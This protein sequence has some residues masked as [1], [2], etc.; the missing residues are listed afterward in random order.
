MRSLT[1]I[2]YLLFATHAYAESAA[3]PDTPLEALLLPLTEQLKV[4]D[5]PHDY[6]SQKFVGLFND[7]DRF[8]GDER[9]YQEANQ[10]VFQLDLHKVSGFAGDRQVVL[11]GRANVSLPNTEKRLH[12]LVE[13]NPDKNITGETPINQPTPIKDVSAPSSYA[14]AMRYEQAIR[15][16]L[17]L[18]TDAGIKFQGLNSTP[19]TRAR[20]S[21]ATPLDKWRMKI[22]ET[23]FWFNS[24]GIGASSQLDFERSLSPPMLMR[25]SSNATWLNDKQNFDLRQ[26]LSIFH[27][28]NER[29]AVLYQAS[30]TGASQPQFHAT[31]YV[32]LVLF[33]YRLHQKWMFFEVSPQLHFPQIK[34]YQTSPALMLR[35]EMLFD[36]GR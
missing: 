35:L 33:R 12:L 19:F 6:L 8:F 2:F 32:L 3:Q 31:D 29:T 7:I 20:A 28:F 9:Y 23:A 1:M 16:A 21:Y 18:S 15:D 4:L 13:S 22:T 36:K 14:A 24:T 25:A 10:S 11:G 26:D 27:T 30:A 17:H 34:S 5:E